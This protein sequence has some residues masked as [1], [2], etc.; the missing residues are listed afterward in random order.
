[1]EQSQ[2]RLDGWIPECW[3]VCVL[4]GS[5]AVLDC[6][7]VAA[8]GSSTRHTWMSAIEHQVYTPSLSLAGT[9]HLVQ[10]HRN[11]VAGSCRSGR[12]STL[13]PSSTHTRTF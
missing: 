1:M 11:A 7:P 8:L 10:V 5:S 13:A 3:A 9:N 12:S 4:G 6:V 2:E